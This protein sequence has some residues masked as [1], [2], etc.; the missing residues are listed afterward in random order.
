MPFGE[1]IMKMSCMRFTRSSAAFSGFDCR[2]GHREQLNLLS[3]YLD[4]TQIY[5]STDS[6][7]QSLRSLV[8]GQMRTSAGVE[9]QENLVHASDNACL[10]TNNIIQCFGAGEGRTNE[11]LGLVSLHTLFLREHNRIARSLSNLNRHWDDNRLYF[12]TRRIIIGIYQNIIYKEW[13][14]SV[15]GWKTAGI[16]DLLPQT[17][18]TYY[19]GYD[20]NVISLITFYGLKIL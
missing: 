3:S 20:Q 5:G 7:A 1:N 2:L 10:D 6:R 16:F 14:P 4:S 18:D 11:N 13:L 12:E 17:S 8:S 9:N 19:K 15:I